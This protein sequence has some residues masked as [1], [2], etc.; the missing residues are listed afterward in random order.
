ML[1]ST[2]D[3]SL[4]V[5]CG[6]ALGLPI[7]SRVCGECL[8][9]LSS[10]CLRGSG[11]GLQA[12]EIRQNDLEHADNAALT[13][14]ASEG[15]VKGFRDIV[16]GPAAPLHECSGARGL[17]VEV[18]QQLRGLL[19]RRNSDLSIRNGYRV[20]LLFRS[21]NLSGRL[22]GGI[23]LSDLLVEVRNLGRQLLARRGHLLDARSELL[24]TRSLLLTGGLVGAHFSIAE[25]L[26]LC[27]V[28]SFLLELRDHVLDHL[29][30]LHKGVRTDTDRKGRKHPRVQH[31]S[32]CVQEVGRNSLD[33]VAVSE[34]RERSLPLLHKAR[35]VLRTR[36]GDV[37]RTND[38]HGLVD[39]YQL[40]STQLL[41]SRP[42]LHKA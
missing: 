36:T 14:G 27:L 2:L 12:L 39:G 23:D 9:L 6:L 20:L 1:C 26:V 29:P 32:L 35:Q 3:C 34:L 5:V 10:S 22:H 41:P 25:S 40:L 24:D 38:F 18:L 31:P 28:G 33:R 13:A 7:L 21:A 17:C 4:L 30:D 16:L 11:L 37:L 8:V 42:L 19:D 15:L